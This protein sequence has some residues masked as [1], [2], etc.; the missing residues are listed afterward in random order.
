M[1]H[2][3]HV[4]LFTPFNVKCFRLGFQSYNWPLWL[5][6][7]LRRDI[8]SGCDQRCPNWQRRRLRLA[9]QLVPA[10]TTSAPNAANGHKR[11]VTVT[12]DGAPYAPCSILWLFCFLHLL[13]FT[14]TFIECMLSFHVPA[15]SAFCAV[16][17]SILL[18]QA[19]Y[20]WFL[21]VFC[22]SC[23]CCCLLF[24]LYVLW[25]VGCGGQLEQCQFTPIIHL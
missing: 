8:S 7:R 23:L 15:S 5:N 21:C 1:L 10:T 24:V 17:S 20:L 13:L 18:T 2:S 11:Q 14:M 22:V 25:G 9:L 12:L 16:P 4:Q 6:C 19:T 3:T